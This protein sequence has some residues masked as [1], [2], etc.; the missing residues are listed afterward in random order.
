MVSKRLE[1]LCSMVTKGNRLADIGTDHALLP[2]A[3]VQ[4]RIVPHA[5]A[6]DVKEG[7]LQHAK[8]NIAVAGLEDYIE[9]RLSDGLKG[10]QPGETDTV[11]ISGMGGRLM[12]KIL[13]GW[14][15][16]DGV[17]EWIFQPQSELAE[18]RRYLARRGL[19]IT[20]ERML[21]ENEKY[22][23]IL[24]CKPGSPYEAD[25]LSAAFGPILLARRDA[26]LKEFLEKE[27]Q[28]LLVL[29][30]GLKDTDSEKAAARAK[31][32]NETGLLISNAIDLLG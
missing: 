15:V 18:F 26:V 2:I 7:P 11:L 1:M 31:E 13:D 10:L 25:P 3:L 16:L 30:D 32:L 29:L 14:D 24:Q 22:Y 28:T 19:V 12:T 21:C 23:T 20:D 4:K 8:D 27:M 17:K 9:T 6:M 5:I